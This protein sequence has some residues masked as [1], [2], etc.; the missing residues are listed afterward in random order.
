MEQPRNNGDKTTAMDTVIET[1]DVV[2]RFETG[3]VVGGSPTIS[4]YF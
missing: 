3:D 4:L 1:G 2:G